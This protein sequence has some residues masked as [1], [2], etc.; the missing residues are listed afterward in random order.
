LLRRAH[1]IGVPAVGWR[2]AVHYFEDPATGSIYTLAEL[3]RLLQGSGVNLNEALK[4]FR[5]LPSRTCVLLDE[6]EWIA[7]VAAPDERRPFRT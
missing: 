3:R 5:K 7:A 6:A 4:L 2:L 1:C